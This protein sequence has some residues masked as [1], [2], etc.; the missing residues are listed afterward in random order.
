MAL[1]LAEGAAGAYSPTVAELDA[2]AR[3]AG[4]RRD[5]AQRIGDSVFA[6]EWPAEVSQISVNA[7]DDHMIV[8]IRILGVKFHHPITRS[9]FASEIA[10]LAGRAF[11]AAPSAEELDIWAS[12]PI[13][14][15]KGVVVSGD[16][17]RP[18]SRTVFSVTARRSE[19]AAA[20]EARLDV[21]NG[22]VFWDEQ[23]AQSAFRSSQ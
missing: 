16:L 18:T 17:A 23:W 2:E 12:V 19:S 8:G 4:N 9:E 10:A 14:V 13:G 1:Q 7:L 21:R 15:A 6:T 22:G 11:A 3:A 20:L 5:L